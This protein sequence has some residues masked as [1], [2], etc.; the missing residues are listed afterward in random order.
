MELINIGSDGGEFFE[1]LPVDW[2]GLIVP[3]WDDYYGNATIY[4]FK[5]GL[6]IASGGIV[7]SGEPPNMTVFEIEEGQKY[8]DLGFQYI[9]FLFVDPKFR[10]QAL[11]SKWLRALKEE[12][13]NQ[14]YW[15]TIEEEGLR[16]FYEKNGFKCVSESKD[17]HNKEWIFTYQA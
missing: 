2:Q 3:V 12:F 4:V 11:G 9:G 7:F 14:S 13:P 15:L 6:K 17:T 10:N 16:P 5:N 1:I 8:V